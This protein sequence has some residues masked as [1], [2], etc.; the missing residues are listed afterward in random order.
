MDP[1][2]SVLPKLEAYGFKTTFFGLSVSI[3]PTL[4]IEMQSKADAFPLE[5]VQAILDESK[6]S[7]PVHLLFNAVKST[8]L[9]H[10]MAKIERLDPLTVKIRVK[11]SP[12]IRVSF[13]V[14]IDEG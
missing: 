9:L 2:I 1:W 14:P 13:G 10:H 4:E 6:A 3:N 7:T 8:M 12:E 5:R 11:L